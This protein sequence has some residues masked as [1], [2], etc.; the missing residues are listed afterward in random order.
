M[1]K[2]DRTY[3]DMINATA[4]NIVA[5]VELNGSTFSHDGALQEFT[6]ERVADPNKLFGFGICQKLDIK[7][8]DK[9]R[10]IN[11]AKDQTANIAFNDL[12]TCP[13]FF[14]E[15]V[16]RDENNNNLTIT[17]YDAIYKAAKH[18]TSELDLPESYTIG[19][20]ATACGN[21]LGTALK[22]NRRNLLDLT[23]C[24]L[25]DCIQNEDGS[26][27]SNIN[28]GYYS[29]ITT[30][31]LNGLLME[32]KGK[33]FTLNVGKAV[34]D[35]FCTIVIY[36]TRTSGSPYQES[37]AL[38]ASSTTITVADDFESIT[39]LELR[40]NRG[41]NLF[42]DTTTTVPFIQ[43]EAGEV[44]TA[45]EPYNT[46]FDV[47]YEGNANIEGTE[48]IR[49]V[50]DD[51]AEATGTIYFINNLN[52]LVFKRLDV[53]GTPVYHIDKSKYFTLSSAEPL[54]IT[55]VVK[56]TALEDNVAV[57][58]EGGTQYLRDN[59]FLDLRDDVVE[60][61]EGILTQ[62]QGL[63][64]EQ[65]VCKWRQNFLLEI[66][67][68]IS[69]EAKD[70]SVINTYLLSDTLTYNGGMVGVTQWEHSEQSESSSNPSTIGDAL[71]YTYA[72]VDK[73]NKEIE[74]VASDVSNN[75]A[76]ISGLRLATDGIQASVEKTESKLNSAIDNV[77]DNVVSLTKRVE[78]K[79]DAE[80]VQIQISEAM[81]EGVSA[82]TT[83]TGFT[84]NEEGLTVSKSNSP[85]STT[86]TE[87]GMTV[88]R[89]ETAL[90]SCNADGVTARNLHANTYL[91][92]GLYSRFENYGEK[93]TGC[94]WI[95]S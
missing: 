74:L 22:V 84:F 72:K 31:A 91:I 80:D 81:S 48:T 17:A 1:I 29:R 58:S 40:F 7:L 68:K 16:Q 14:V 73:V 35:K 43:F 66:G 46:M 26:F 56:A 38:S 77:N 28:N 65:F 41:T 10:A 25:V 61:L 12:Y 88:S 69:F 9:E 34:S 71:K 64:I 11:V 45:Y 39:E 42:T 89:N 87:N 49:D 30:S 13:N 6:V 51:I 90:L 92:V 83:T 15:E 23:K 18:T 85:I 47:V 59:I 52:E 82:V 36:G 60:L 24:R 54:T 55:S 5:K 44:A 67:D 20:L 62:V 4:R 79:M 8:R 86:I 78:A 93:R 37:N 21:A 3:L 50:L 19:E 32:S 63:T 27:T 53:D 2:A 95:G 57:G 76:Q 75:A 33:A 70:G 94:F